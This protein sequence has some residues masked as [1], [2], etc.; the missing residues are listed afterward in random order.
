MREIRNFEK[1]I[2]LLLV[3]A[4]R[5]LIKIDNLFADL[6]D[7]GFQVFC[8]FALRFFRANLFAQSIALGL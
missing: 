6:S 4:R 5:T 3:E 8:R 1:Q 7:L 2:P